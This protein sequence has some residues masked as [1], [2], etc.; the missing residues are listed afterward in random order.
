MDNNELS[1]RLKKCE[2]D[3]LKVFIKI[4]DDHNLQYF[5]VGGTALGAIRHG[6]FIPWDDDID[7]AMP[8]SDYDT[9]ISVAQMYLPEHLFLQT[10]LTDRHYCNIY[11]KIRNSNTAFIETAAKKLHINHGVFIDIFPIDGYPSNIKEQK[12]LKSKCK[13]VKRALS[14]YFYPLTFKRL[15]ISIL[16]HIVLLKLTKNSIIKSFDKMSRKYAYSNYELVT[17]HGGAWGDKEIVKKEYYGK[18]KKIRFE[19]IDVMC[20]EKLDEYLTSKYGNYMMLPPVEK[21]VT[22]HYCDIISLETSYRKIMK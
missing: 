19:N 14:I 10:H 2:L 17:C 6:G 22:H 13:N 1:S 7:V 8:R 16:S 5:I 9:F 15:L 4:C 20:P 18:G 3:I 21:Q 11:A 12:R